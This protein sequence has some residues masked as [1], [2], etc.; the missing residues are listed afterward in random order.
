M[1]RPTKTPDQPRD[2]TAKFRVTD[3]ELSQLE[4][5]A[6]ESGQ[7]IS[8]YL[9]GKALNAQPVRH[10]ASPERAALI[11]A[12]GPLG[13]IRSDINQVL[14]DRWAYKFVEPERVEGIFARIEAIAEHIVNSLEN[15]R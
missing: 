11:V 12:L 15:D 13:S 2:K 10:K 14:K 3:A 6:T 4:R 8:D 1:A 7:T 5:L 9:R